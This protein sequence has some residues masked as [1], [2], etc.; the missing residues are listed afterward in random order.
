VPTNLFSYPV[1]EKERAYNIK[2]TILKHIQHIIN[3]SG[4]FDEELPDGLEDDH[5]YDSLDI[6]SAER[7]AFGVDYLGKRTEPEGLMDLFV[8]RYVGKI[9]RL[10]PRAKFGVQS[11]NRQLLFIHDL[12]VENF[13]KLDQSNSLQIYN[14]SSP[15]IVP[16]PSGKAFSMKLIESIPS[17]DVMSNSRV[18]AIEFT[19]DVNFNI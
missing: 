1:D 5:F 2:W 16:V 12:I 18:N 9:I 14:F 3:R 19:Y 17:K 8:V 4:I 6:D 13:T 15:D 7:P 11:T 10:D